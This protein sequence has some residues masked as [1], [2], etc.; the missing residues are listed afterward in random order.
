VAQ[1]TG[2]SQQWSH[3]HVMDRVCCC[4]R[5]SA[6]KLH[7]PSAFPSFWLSLLTPSTVQ[8][9]VRGD[10]GEMANLLMSCGGKVMEKDGLLVDLSESR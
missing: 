4:V 9:A 7:E 1:Q 5:V 3:A 2:M 10:H 8:D 6:I